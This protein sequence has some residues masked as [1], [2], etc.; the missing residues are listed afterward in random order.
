[1]NWAVLW[2]L[3]DERIWQD[4]GNLPE[5]SKSLTEC[6]LIILDSDICL[7]KKNSM[8]KDSDQL[9]TALGKKSL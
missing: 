5:H 7:L 3:L 6:L 1:M 2:W 8:F 4:L 9:Y